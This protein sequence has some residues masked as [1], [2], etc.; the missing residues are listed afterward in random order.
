MVGPAFGSGLPALFED[1]IV[2]KVRDGQVRNT[3][4]YVAMRVTTNGEREIPGM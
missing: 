3:P 1:V 2:V 4:F